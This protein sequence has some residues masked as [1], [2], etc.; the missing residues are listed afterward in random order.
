MQD[1]AREIERAAHSARERPDALSA[2]LFEAEDGKCLGDARLRLSARKTVQA[3][4][5]S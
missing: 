1:A 4:G 3:R 2:T 5:K